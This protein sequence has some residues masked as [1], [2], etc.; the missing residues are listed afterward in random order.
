M[1]CA[2]AA[3]VVDD[4]APVIANH[5]F[6]F[7]MEMFQETLHRPGRCVA[8]RTNGM[9]LNLVGDL[10]EFLKSSSNPDLQ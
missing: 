10:Q 3:V 1:R 5:V 6:K 9:P 4:A 7:M 2:P 8:E